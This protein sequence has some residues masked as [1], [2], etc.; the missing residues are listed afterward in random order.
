M[1]EYRELIIGAFTLAIGWY[2]KKLTGKKDNRSGEQALIDKLF[3]EIKRV[4]ERIDKLEKENGTLKVENY[5]L[6]KENG[7]FK[8]ENA[9][10]K[11]ENSLLKIEI[12]SLK[13]EIV[14]LRKEDK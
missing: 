4:D 12:A 8:I 5:E 3:L 11:T 13:I 2:G 1:N 14:D 7:T 9:S 6:R 10:L